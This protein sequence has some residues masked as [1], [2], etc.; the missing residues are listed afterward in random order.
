M[1]NAQQLIDHARSVT[2]A[3]EHVLAAGVFAVQDDYV[4]TALAAMGGSAVAGDILDNSV[5]EGVGAAAGVRAAREAHAAGQGVSLRMLLAVT[6]S[7]IRLYRLGATGEDP[8][9]ELVAFDRASC[10][11]D[12]SKFGASEHLDLRQGDKEINL[13]GGVGLLATYKDGN[14]RVVQELSK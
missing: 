6:P 10:E 13:T 3:E 11:V 5:A 2:P 1:A 14:K 12:L 9:E 4:A 8:G 7:H